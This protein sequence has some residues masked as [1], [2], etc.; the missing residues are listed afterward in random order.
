MIYTLEGMSPT[1]A[2]YAMSFLTT[3]VP[4]ARF[5]PGAQPGQLVAWATPKVHEEI[6]NLVDQLTQEESPEKAPKVVVYTLKSATAT[7]AMQVLQTA[8]PQA[9]VT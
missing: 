4:T 1:A 8:V 2:S 6:A 5:T 3:A 9:N 7:S